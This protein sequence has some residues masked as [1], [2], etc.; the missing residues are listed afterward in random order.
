MLSR[1][2]AQSAAG[3]RIPPLIV[4]LQ[5]GGIY[6]AY[7]GLP[8]G[9]W[10][11]ARSRPPT[12]R[13]RRSSGRPSTS[14]AM[15][16]A[17]FDLNL[18][19]IADVATLDSALAD[20]AFSDD[21]ELVTAMTTASVR[22]CRES[23]P[24]LRHPL[25]PRARGRFEQ[26]R[27][28]S[29]DRGPRRGLARNPRPRPLPGGHRRDGPRRSWSRWPSTPP[30]TRSPPPR[31]PQRSPADLL[32]DELG[33]KGVADQ[34]RPLRRRPRDGAA[35]ARGRRAGPG[36]RHRPGRDQRSRRGGARR[37]RPSWRR[38]APGP[39]RRPA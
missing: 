38:P 32:R 33:F 4:G 19:P 21:P 7:P 25:L 16:K 39:C 14:R 31:S 30:T 18:A 28:R 23:R 8:P 27:R 11:S 2:R 15:A 12:T 20:R 29:G 24:R 26:H 37:E 36:G 1:L 22:G 35:R 6:R 13:P 9:S 3:G 34:R 10:A 17:G 5:E